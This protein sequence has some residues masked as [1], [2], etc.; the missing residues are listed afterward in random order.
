MIYENEKLFTA[1]E[2]NIIIRT[3]LLKIQVWSV[4]LCDVDS[5][6]MLKTNK[7]NGSLK[8]LMKSV[9]YISSKEKVK[10]RGVYIMTN[11]K[12]YIFIWKNI[13]ERKKWIKYTI[14]YGIWV[15]TIIGGKIERKLGKGFKITIYKKITLDIK[16]TV[17]LGIEGNQCG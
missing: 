10:Y 15:A 17:L 7:K 1:H 13:M 11:D 14:R 5:W 3:T 8:N 2:I 4:A 16:K 6:T 12:K 9:K